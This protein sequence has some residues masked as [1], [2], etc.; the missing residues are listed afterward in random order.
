MHPSQIFAELA[1]LYTLE[2]EAAHAYAAAVAAVSS[3]P[4]QEELSL[5]GL[6]HQRHAIEL[7]QA[8]LSL[9]YNAPEVT[10]D[11]KGVV[12]GALTLPRRRLT[13]E[14][15][16]EGIRG[17]EQLTNSVYAKALAK[18]LP[19]ETRELLERLRGDERRHLAWADRMVSRRI[20]LQAGADAHP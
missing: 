16:L 8:I 3:G 4:V 14:D 9:G 19:A 17:D 13:L 12:I 10:P 20:W 2:V 18:P 6:E 11:V 1:R 5:F 15:V 7:H